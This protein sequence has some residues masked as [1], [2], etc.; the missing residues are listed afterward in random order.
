M[1]IVSGLSAIVTLGF[2]AN[3]TD[4]ALSAI[5]SI[6][7]IVRLIAMMWEAPGLALATAQE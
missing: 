3:V 2:G 4:F 6:R 7:P 5:Q 1:Q